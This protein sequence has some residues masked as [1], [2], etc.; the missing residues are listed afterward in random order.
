MSAIEITR[1]WAIGEVFE[2]AISSLT[3]CSSIESKVANFSL[4]GQGVMPSYLAR[5]SGRLLSAA[6]AAQMM[7]A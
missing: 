5:V 7:W 4:Q 3:G 1:W 2:S 6:S